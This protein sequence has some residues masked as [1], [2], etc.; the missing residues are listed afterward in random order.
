MLA[1]PWSLWTPTAATVHTPLKTGLGGFARIGS[2]SSKLYLSMSPKGPDF[3][4]KTLVKRPLFCR[5]WLDGGLKMQIKKKDCI[6]V[7]CF[8][9]GFPPPL[10]LSHKKHKSR[11]TDAIFFVDKSCRDF[12]LLFLLFILNAQTNTGGRN[13]L[14]PFP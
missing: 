6:T 8:H 9:F 4:F 10:T 11:I 7:P 1:G 14:H 2:T 12:I 5:S 13:D 3:L